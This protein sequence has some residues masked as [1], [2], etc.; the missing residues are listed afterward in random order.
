M[1]RVNF[2]AGGNMIFDLINRKAWER[3]AQALAE[4]IAEQ[5]QAIWERDCAIR[6]RDRE[7]LLRDLQIAELRRQAAEG[8]DGQDAG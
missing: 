8:R 6:E 4:K 1:T 3:K 7:I 2:I 5:K